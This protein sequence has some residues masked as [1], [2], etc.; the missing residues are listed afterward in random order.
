M[1]RLRVQHVNSLRSSHSSASSSHV[2]NPAMM[3]ELI[4]LTDKS[5]SDKLRLMLCFPVQSSVLLLPLLLLL[6][7]ALLYLLVLVPLLCLPDGS[8]SLVA[9]FRAPSRC[10]QQELQDQEEQAQE[11]QRVKAAVRG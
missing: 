4:V 9:L 3:R 6:L 8:R 11:K 2:N 5:A 10:L 7:L 1:R